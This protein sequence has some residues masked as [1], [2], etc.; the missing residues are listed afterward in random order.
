MSNVYP[1][2]RAL[3]LVWFFQFKNQ[4]AAKAGT[5]GIIAADVTTM[6]NGYEWLKALA[7]EIEHFEHEAS[8]RVAFYQLLAHGGATPSGP[9]DFTAVANP[10][11]PMPLPGLLKLLRKLIGRI[12]LADDYTESAGKDLGI[13]ATEGASPSPGLVKPVGKVTALAG[14]Q[15]ELKWGKQGFKAVRVLCKRGAETVM[16]DLGVKLGSSFIDTRPPLVAGQ[17]EVRSY[18]L[19][20]IEDDEP[21]GQLSDTMAVSTMP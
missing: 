4:L 13:E 16:T 18:Q 21:V 12:K 7:D 8:E 2:S 17:P 6:S 19:Q 3:F 9:P 14:S 15:V 10:L 20:F 11:V 5:L 1:E